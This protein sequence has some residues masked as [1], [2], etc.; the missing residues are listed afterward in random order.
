MSQLAIAQ[1]VQDLARFGITVGIVLLGLQRAQELQRPA[2]KFRIDEN[3]LQRNDQTVAPKR[4]NEPGQAG[5][6]K[7]DYMVCVLDRQ[8]ERGHVLERLAEQTVEFF[9]AGLNPCHVLQP[10]RHRPGMVGLVALPEAILWRVQKLLA[11]LKRVEQ[12]GVPSL[13]RLKRDLE[14]EPS[15]SRDRFAWCARYR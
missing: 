13:V 14:A 4:S 2:G 11:I 9:I 15:V 8:T 3:I 5:S 10:L 7:E 6:R 12:A 1:F